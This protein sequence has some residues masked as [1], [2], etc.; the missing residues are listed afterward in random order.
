MHNV[1]IKFNRVSI[2]DYLKTPLVIRGVTDYF[3]NKSF[4][5]INIV[6]ANVTYT[7]ARQLAAYA[8]SKRF[9][10]WDLYNTKG[11]P[12]IAFINLTTEYCNAKLFI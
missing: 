5:E 4:I 11:Q 7:R 9:N 1:N 8:K 10:F 6:A 2:N 12:T 3:K